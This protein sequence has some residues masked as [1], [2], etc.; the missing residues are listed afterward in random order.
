MPPRCSAATNRYKAKRRQRVL[1]AFQEARAK[2]RP[3]L[4]LRFLFL[5]EDVGR[6]VGQ[7]VEQVPGLPEPAVVR[8]GA[9]DDDRDLMIALRQP[10]QRCQAVAGLA[11]EAGLPRQDV[12]LA[13]A[14]QVIGVADGDR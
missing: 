4:L 11:D 6:L 2:S 12:D 9:E 10:Q 3:V 1:T 5:A 8:A 14:H 13:A 7:P